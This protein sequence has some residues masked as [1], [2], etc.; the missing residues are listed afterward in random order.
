MRSS[1]NSYLSLLL[2][3]NGDYLV[4]TKNLTFF[5]AYDTYVSDF[6]ALISSITP[7]SS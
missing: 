7:S 4:C 3:D 2:L 5:R 6:A 1:L